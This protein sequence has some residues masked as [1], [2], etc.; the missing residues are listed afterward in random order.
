MSY[1]KDRAFAEQGP[2]FS[3]ISACFACGDEIVGPI[4]RHDGYDAGG[5]GV[6]LY[7]HR[8]CAF[9][10]AQ[11][12]VVDSWPNRRDGQFMSVEERARRER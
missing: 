5:R 3:P 10:M 9:V 6:S 8:D 11:R 2:S 1:F 7:M 4:V 12:L